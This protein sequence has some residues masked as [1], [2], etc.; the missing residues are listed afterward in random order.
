MF[1]RLI[2]TIFRL[3]MKY[4]LSSITYIGCLYGVGRGKVGTRSRICQRVWAVWAT[5][6]AHAVTKLCLSLLQLNLWQVSYYVYAIIKRRNMQL[7]FM[8]KILYILPINIV[9]LDEYTHCTLVI[10]LT[11]VLS[12][13]TNNASNFTILISHYALSDVQCNSACRPF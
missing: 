9:V 1:R 6:G 12:N 3:Y 13:S 8:Q 4:L 5:R 10:P 2:M 7:Y 11:S